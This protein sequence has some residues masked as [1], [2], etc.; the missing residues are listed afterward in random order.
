M[1][2]SAVKRKRVVLTLKDK[3]EIVEAL[4][5]GESGCSLAEKHGVGTSTVSDIKKKS[6]SISRFSKGLMGGK[7]D[8]ER[9]A[10][11]K[12]LNE[13]VDQAVCLWYMQK[14]SIGQP[15]S[16]PLLCEKALDFNIKLGGSSNF[17]ARTGWLQ[18]FKKRHRIRE[19]EIHGEKLSASESSASKFRD[20]M[21]SY[22]EQQ[23]YKD[24]FIYS[25]ADETGIAWA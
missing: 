21:K 18:K 4:N 16:G 22:L 3:I 5:K 9:K 19:I 15:I 8:P 13:A 17:R 12:P 1:S 25:A 23:G 7:G 2:T 6:E 14:R 11:K 20:E 24:E 10:M